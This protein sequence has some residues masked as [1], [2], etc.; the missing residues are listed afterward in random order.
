MRRKIMAVIIPLAALCLFAPITKVKAE[1]KNNI[2]TAEGAYTLEI[3]A[4]VS[5]NTTT[6]KGTLPITGTLSSCYNLE[7]SITSANNYKLKNEEDVVLPYTLSDEK[8]VFSKEVNSTDDTLK[9]YDLTIQVQK[10]PVV[11]GNYTDT[12]TFT[13]NAKNYVQESTKHKLIFNTNSDT[14][15]VTISTNK[16]FV[17]ENTPYGTLPIPKRKGYTFEGWYTEESGG[18]KVDES[19]IM[20][21]ADKTIFA[22]WKA[23]V[24]TINYHSGGAQTWK[25]YS[26]NEIVPINGD[27]E[28]VQTERTA[29]DDVYDHAQYGL[30]DV[31]RLTKKGYTSGSA[32]KINSPDSEA[33]VT[34]TNVPNPDNFRGKDVAALIGNGIP[35]QLE[36]GDV[37]VELY[38]VFVAN[39]YTVRYEAN[40]TDATGST[41]PSKQTYD[42]EFMLAKNGFIRDGY[43]FEC[44]VKV[45]IIDGKEVKTTYSEGETVSNL[46]DKGGE[47]VVLYA[48]WKKNS[49]S[50]SSLE[51]TGQLSDDTEKECI[52]EAEM[53]ENY[54]LPSETMINDKNEL[55]EI[56]EDTGE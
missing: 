31:G 22:Q 20:G 26:D 25:Q 13:M 5:V 1:T 8:V 55:V 18:D 14:D 16:K 17:N 42:T 6:N 37:T 51:D 33:K 41:E 34:D 45:E 54:S 24:L 52:L 2:Y 4:E 39:T 50:E 44:W 35:E 7:V 23:N 9:E 56:Q 43:T 19:S 30:L 21:N 48:R 3:P 10:K 28:I 12:L 49:A 29:Y 11:S 46:T 40:V 38:P 15:E 27:D 36:L 47:T 32:W 53:K